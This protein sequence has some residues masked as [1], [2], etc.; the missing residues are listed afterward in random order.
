MTGF[1]WARDSMFEEFL[2]IKNELY[3]A[4]D[5]TV[6]NIYDP[7]YDQLISYYTEYTEYLSMASLDSPYSDDQVKNLTENQQAF[8]DIER[9][10]QNYV[11]FMNNYREP[12]KRDKLIVYLFS[13]S[14]FRIS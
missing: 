11:T 10:H 1:K 13:R 2:I 14:F 8:A 5:V 9:F 4:L 12:E 3:V 6:S 7:V